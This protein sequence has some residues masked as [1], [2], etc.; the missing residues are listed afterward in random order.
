MWTFSQDSGAISLDGAPMGTGYAGRGAD[1]DNPSAQFVVDEG[2]LPQGFYTI[3]AFHRDPKLGP[4]MALTPDASNIM[5]GRGGFF[6]HLENPSHP[7]W[8]S[9]GCIVVPPALIEQIAASSDKRL[10]VTV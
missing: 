8:S 2:P 5:E 6:M 1:K 7:G 4:C 9:E 10:Q 3:G